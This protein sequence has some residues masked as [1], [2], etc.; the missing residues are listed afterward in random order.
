MRK[1]PENRYGP[2]V[3]GNVFEWASDWYG[4]K[5]Y[6]EKVSLDPRGPEH[7]QDDPLTPARGPGGH[8][9]RVLRGGNWAL[10]SRYQRGSCRLRHDM[11]QRSAG[12]GLRC[13]LEHLP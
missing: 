5:Y 12:G 13:V 11:D 9:Y 4:P 3:L 10:N 7:P 1:R 8:Q 6:R 2:L